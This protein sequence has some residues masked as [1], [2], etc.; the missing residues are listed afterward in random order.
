MLVSFDQKKVMQKEDKPD[1]RTRS[2]NQHLELS[3]LRNPLFQIG[4]IIPNRILIQCQHRI[5]RVSRL[6]IHFVKGLQ[7]LLWPRQSGF[8]VADIG[9]H[10]FGTF[11]AAAICDG[12]CDGEF[13]GSGECGAADGWF[14]V[15]ESGVGETVAE[16]KEGSEG[17]S[18]V[19]AVANVEALAVDDLHVLTGPVVVCRIILE[20]FGERSLLSSE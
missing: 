18:V 7:F 8:R 10:S 16:G 15:C 11:D 20:T 13:V 1:I 14:T 2:T 4:V 6:Q 19:V 9:L 17:H 12:E 3:L 5:L